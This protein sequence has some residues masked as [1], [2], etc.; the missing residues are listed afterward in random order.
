MNE[1]PAGQSKA[2]LKREQKRFSAETKF[3]REKLEKL[4]KDHELS[5][6]VAY[7]LKQDL[8][9]KTDMPF[10]GLLVARPKEMNSR[11]NLFSV[12]KGY[13]QFLISVADEK[14]SLNL[15]QM[16]NRQQGQILRRLAKRQGIKKDIWDH[17][18][19]TSYV[20]SEIM[21][22]LKLGCLNDLEKLLRLYSEAGQKSITKAED[23]KLTQ[24][25]LRNK[26]PTGWNWRN[27]DANPFARYVEAGIGQ[28]LTL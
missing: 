1:A 10:Y 9:K 3:F 25:G 22:M 20:V 5:E 27:Q 11:S 28:P 17:V 21:A 24:K 13:V 2:S 4:I 15:I 7:H 12:V 18:I 23:A 26:M 6:E 8:K 19:P 16:L 14:F